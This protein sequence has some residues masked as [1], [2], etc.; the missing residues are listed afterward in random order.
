L[1]LLNS[2]W[3]CSSSISSSKWIFPEWHGLV[4]F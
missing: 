1:L 3:S 2:G 4:S